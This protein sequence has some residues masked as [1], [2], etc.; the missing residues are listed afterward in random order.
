MLSKVTKNK[1][2]IGYFANK[3]KFL[4]FR[5]ESLGICKAPKEPQQISKDGAVPHCVRDAPND[6]PPHDRVA[7]E[8]SLICAA[9]PHCG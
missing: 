3:S 2:L 4:S 1:M 7:D 9:Y 6:T 5:P 8:V